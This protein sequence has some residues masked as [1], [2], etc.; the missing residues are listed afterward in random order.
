[1]RLCDSLVNFLHQTNAKPNR[2]TQMSRGRSSTV[3]REVLTGADAAW[4]FR[5]G[6]DGTMTRS[7]TA[8][9]LGVSLATI[10]RKLTAGVFRKGK[11]PDTGSTLICKRSVM[12]YL[13]R[14]EA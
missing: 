2:K 6:C 10:D 3:D 12:T 4:G 14:L 5:F 13:E 1:L 9:F 8:A 7:K 11:D